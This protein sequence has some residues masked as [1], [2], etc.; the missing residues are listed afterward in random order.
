MAEMYRA[1]DWP[2]RNSAATSAA[3]P[4]ASR[5]AASYANTLFT[6]A[7]ICCQ[8]SQTSMSDRPVTRS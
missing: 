3:S 4:K 8:L 2:I 6:G 7:P 1:T 5:Q